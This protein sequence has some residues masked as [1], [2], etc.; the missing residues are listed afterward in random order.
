MTHSTSTPSDLGSNTWSSPFDDLLAPGFPSLIDPP[1]EAAIQPAATQ[2]GTPGQD[3]LCWDGAQS[4]D[5]T[6]AIRCQEFILEQF[7]GME[8]DEHALVQQAMDAGVYAPG[9]GT[10]PN[11]VGTLLELNGIPVTRYEGASVFNLAHELAQ[12]HK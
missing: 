10:L 5:D 11:D 8:V 9:C 7:T 12:G 4:Y 2:M 1:G 6:C 3:I